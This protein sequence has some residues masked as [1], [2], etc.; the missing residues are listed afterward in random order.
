LAEARSGEVPAREDQGKDTRAGVS[1]D[2]RETFM[3]NKISTKE[4]D[5]I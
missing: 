5:R 2:E 1:R 3:K 4:K